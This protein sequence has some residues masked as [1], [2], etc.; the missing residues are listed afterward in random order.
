MPCEIVSQ[1]LNCT[2]AVRWE[3]IA[4][5]SQDLESGLFCCQVPERLVA[6]CLELTFVE[7]LGFGAYLCIFSGSLWLLHKREQG[8][9]QCL[10]LGSFFFL[11]PS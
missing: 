6:V 5:L 3:L 11:G 9:I 7:L 1:L 10:G 8:G 2:T 4:L